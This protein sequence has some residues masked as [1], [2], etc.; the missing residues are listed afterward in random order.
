MDTLNSDISGKP[1]QKELS[2]K[3]DIFNR[4]TGVHLEIDASKEELADNKIFNA[5]ELAIQNGRKWYKLTK[6]KESGRWDKVPTS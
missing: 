4:S 5:M 6:N 2:Y 3:V 1:I